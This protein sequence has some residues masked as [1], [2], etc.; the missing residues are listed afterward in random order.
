M[1]GLVDDVRWQTS[2]NQIAQ[3]LSTPGGQKFVETN[4][5]TDHM[6]ALEPYMGQ[7]MESNFALGRDSAEF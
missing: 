3:I 7:A 4:P 1:V 5:R 6:E 2:A